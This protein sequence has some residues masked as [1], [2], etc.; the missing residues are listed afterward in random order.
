MLSAAV[1]AS[2][3]THGGRAAVPGP[4]TQPPASQAPAGQPPASQ[5]AAS[6][7]RQ[8]GT[9]AAG[10]SRGTLSSHRHRTVAPPSAGPSPSA[11][12]SS[13]TPHPTTAGPCSASSAVFKVGARTWPNCADTGVPAGTALREMTSPNPTGDGNSLVTEITQSGTVING[14]T[15]TGS[16]DVSA[17]NVTIENSVIRSDNWWGINQ[18]AGY[19]GL[20]V[21]HC[22]IIGLPGRGP[23]NGAEDYAVSSA[24]GS[25][26]VGW[27]NLSGFGDGISLGTGYIHDNYVHDLQAFIPAGSSTYNHDDAFISDGGS[28]LIIEHNTLLNQ[29]PITEGASSSVGLYYESSPV[30]S[31]TVKDNFLAG[32]SYALYP[33]GGPSSQDVVITGNVFSTMYW[34]G[35]GYYG[36]VAGSYWHYGSGNSWSD[37]TWA[38]GPKAGQEVQPG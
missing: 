8:L 36:P 12:T 20:R 21:L 22:T 10:R 18:R 27:S 31:V 29:V 23:D 24:G 7:A 9:H 25:S 14:V 17:N 32:G 1:L 30:T 19:S 37:N 26:E 34:P 6:P 2:D 16:I 13:P 15:L 5:A 4:R 35:S 38:D 28:G 11:P 3:L 33:G